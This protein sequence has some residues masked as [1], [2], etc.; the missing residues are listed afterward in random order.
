MY[1]QG[2]LFSYLCFFLSLLPVV[3]FNCII[4]WCLT[5]F[6]FFFFSLLFQFHLDSSLV[7]KY[8][9]CDLCSFFFLPVDVIIHKS[10]WKLLFVTHYMY[11]LILYFIFLIST[12]SQIKLF[13]VI[14]C[15]SIFF[16]SLFYFKT[17]GRCCGYFCWW[18]WNIHI[19]C[20][21]W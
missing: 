15:K 10:N 19:L 18:I 7:C 9:V 14:C 1:F 20:I 21:H 8:T 17:T 11:Q 5:F 3:V 16:H 12:S 4:I 6:F 2:D 13:L